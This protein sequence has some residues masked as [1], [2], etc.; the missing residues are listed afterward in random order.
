MKSTALQ[1]RC[2]TS[3]NA[4]IRRSR[5]FSTCRWAPSNRVSPEVW[6]NY[7]NCSPAPLPTRPR[8]PMNSQQAKEILGLYRPGTADQQDADFAA[9][10]ALAKS[11]ATLQGWFEEHCAL[12]AALQAKFRQIPIPEGL[13]E[14]ILSERKAHINLPSRR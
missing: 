13:K 12:Q 8:N 6:A 5:R 1:C 2:F 10:L 4:P 11:D 14:Q 7:K 3:R 9:A